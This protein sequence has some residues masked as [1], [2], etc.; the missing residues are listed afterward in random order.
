M[1]SVI[2]ILIGLFIAFC[3]L[4]MLFL[5]KEPPQINWTT[6]EPVTNVEFHPPYTIIEGEEYYVN[7]Y[8]TRLWTQIDIIRNIYH[9]IRFT[10]ITAKTY[11]PLDFKN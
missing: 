5:D 1:K 2:I 3:I 8:N 4:S 6:L 9:Y 10:K 7:E 11:N